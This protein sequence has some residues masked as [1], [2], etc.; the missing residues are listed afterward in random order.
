MNLMSE[1]AQDEAEVVAVIEQYIESYIDADVTA[2][3]G[4]FA[5][6]AIMNGYL[7]G[8]LIEGT[9]EPFFRQVAANPSLNSSG[10]ELKYNIEYVSI[11]HNAAS[12]VLRE[13]GFGPYNFT[14]YMHLLKRDG[15]WKI[16]SKTFTTY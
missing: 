13:I 1:Q 16:I 3:R 15:V 12:V 9:P 11:T 4:V 10:L 2:L 8:R 7:D 14:D 5:S 6:D